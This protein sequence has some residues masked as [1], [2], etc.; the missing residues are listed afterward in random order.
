MLFAWEGWLVVAC[1]HKFSEEK[2][3]YA[4][5]DIQAHVPCE[6]Y[7]VEMISF[8]FVCTVSASYLLALRERAE[9]LGGLAAW[10]NCYPRAPCNPTKNS[11]T[12]KS[13][14]EFHWEILVCRT[15]P[16]PNDLV[17]WIQQAFQTDRSRPSLRSKSPP[18]SP[19]PQMHPNPSEQKRPNPPQTTL[20]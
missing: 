19:R 4:I 10:Q 3:L 18:N 5:K 7:G 12:S 1:L 17:L 2:Q 8:S 13:L 9:T 14:H 16:R 15:T 6:A 20:N 11:I